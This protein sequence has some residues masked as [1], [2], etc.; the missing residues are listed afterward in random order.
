MSTYIIQ[1]IERKNTSTGKS[2]AKVTLKDK[3]TGVVAEDVA[4]W[5][6]FPGF[7]DLVEGSETQGSI[8]EKQVG[9][10]TNRM[11]RAGT[12]N[13]SPIKAAIST[14][15][16][17]ETKARGIERAQDRKEESIRAASIIRD[18]TILTAAFAQGKDVSV[19]D[20]K[21]V[22]TNWN[23]WLTKQWDNPPSLQ[24]PPF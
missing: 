9:K 10:Y 24:K 3:E 6:D 8:E 2:L 14:G 11:L 23:V 18:S 7:F 22:W 15:A 21:E 12:F 4:I 17:M 13:P 5:A 20:M 16:A 1:W 19:D